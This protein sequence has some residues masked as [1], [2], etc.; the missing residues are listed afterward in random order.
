MQFICQLVHTTMCNTT[1]LLQLWMA[2]IVKKEV[3]FQIGYSSNYQ[4]VSDVRGL[5]TFGDRKYHM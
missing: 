2:N 5:G 3:H 1:G 4:L